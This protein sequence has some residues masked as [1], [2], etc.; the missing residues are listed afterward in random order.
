MHE[1][2]KSESQLWNGFVRSSER[3]P[4]RPAIQVGREITYSELAERA[5][6]SKGTIVRLEAG[7]DA[8]PPTVRKLAEALGVDPAQ[9]V[10]RS[11]PA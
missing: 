2:V 4:Q 11:T 1:I 9:L 5:R 10:G 7:N 6:V 8:H 3:F